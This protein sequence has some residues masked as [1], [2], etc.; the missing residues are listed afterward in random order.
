MTFGNGIK[1]RQLLNSHNMARLN[2]SL[3][4]ARSP[5]GDV[6][7]AA[8]VA[9]AGTSRR[10]SNGGVV[11]GGD[12]GPSLI[13]LV[14]DPNYAT[15]RCAGA[16]EKVAAS[17]KRPSWRMAR[18]AA[19]GPRIGFADATGGGR[20]LFCHAASR[21]HEF[22]GR[23]G[24]VDRTG[25]RLG[26]GQL[27]LSA[28]PAQLRELV[29]LLAYVGVAA[30]S[31]LIYDRSVSSW[32]PGWLAPWYGGGFEIATGG[33][34]P[35]LADYRLGIRCHSNILAVQAAVVA[36]LA[37]A[38]ALQPGKRVAFCWAVFTAG[39]AI[40]LL[41]RARTA[42]ATSWRASCAIHVSA[43]RLANGCFWH[44]WH[45]VAFVLIIAAGFGLLDGGG[46]NSAATW[47]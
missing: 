8:P 42:L 46:V 31:P 40:V 43:A 4:R 15:A 32:P 21:R 25:A 7:A 26:G 41:T 38:F 13:G 44:R 1:L 34:K 6:A 2:P 27:E 37:Y 24:D 35:G 20:P 33:I 16:V 30:A 10:E 11:R 29:R 5:H 18:V 9:V 19:M 47:A 28:E 17:T 22:A 36:I 14:I 12:F 23:L 45:V 3:L 39:G